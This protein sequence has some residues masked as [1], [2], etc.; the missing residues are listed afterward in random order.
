[1]G[2]IAAADGD[3]ARFLSIYREYVL[4]KEVTAKRIYLETMQEVFSGMDKVIIDNSGG[5]GVVTYL[6]LPELRKRSQAAE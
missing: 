1:M 3:A 6:P 2:V 5:P 4:A